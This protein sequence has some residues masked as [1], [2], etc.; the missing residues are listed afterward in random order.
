MNASITLIKNKYDSANIV[1]GPLTD[2]RS[3]Y[4]DGQKLTKSY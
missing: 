1:R 4:S 3:F 2:T